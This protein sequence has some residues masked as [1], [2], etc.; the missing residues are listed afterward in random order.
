MSALWVNINRNGALGNRLFSRAHVYAAARE[1][2]AVV[3]DWGLGDYKRLFPALPAG[4]L[5]SYPFTANGAVPELPD[6]WWLNEGTLGFLRRARPR[7][8]GQHGPIWSCYWGGADPDTMAL[9]GPAF[10][11]FAAGRELLFLD[12]YKLRCTPWVRKHADEIRRFFALPQAVTAKWT[13][14]QAQWHRQWPTTVAVHMRGTDFR[15]A[16]G[17]RYYLS[18]AEYASVLKSSDAI[19]PATTLFVLFSDESFRKDANFAALASAFAGL[20]HIFMHGDLADDMAGIGSCDRIVG[21]VTSTFSRWA[22][23]ARAR[24]W[25]GVSRSMLAGEAPGLQFRSG[26]VPWDYGASSAQPET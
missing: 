16:Q 24:P 11:E 9:D 8:T 7:R 4:Q 12:G 21:P 20:D 5:A 14:L 23:F 26:L 15:K 2:G 17:G 22:V 10:A 25:A 6:R 1:F 3:A 13:A 19:D 18:P